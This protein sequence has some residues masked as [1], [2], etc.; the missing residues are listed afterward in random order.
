MAMQFRRNIDRRGSIDVAPEP[1][2]GY[3]NIM[4]DL[5]NATRY[6]HWFCWS[7]WW[8]PREKNSDVWLCNFGETLTGKGVLMQL[9]N[10][11]S[12]VPE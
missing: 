2:V 1:L 12:I 8:G 9:M 6:M 11:Q 4:K 5:K 7:Y 3:L 10:Y